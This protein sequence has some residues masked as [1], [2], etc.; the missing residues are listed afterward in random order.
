MNKILVALVFFLIGL[1]AGLVAGY[2]FGS[3]RVTSSEVKQ[4]AHEAGAS[5]ENGASDVATTA[6]QVVDS[7]MIVTLGEQNKSGEVGVATL[8]DQDGQT[9]VVITMASAPNA[10]VSASQPAHIHLGACPSPGAVK[11]PLTNVVNGNSETMVPV[12]IAQLKGM[13]PLAINVHK[14]VAEISKYVACGD[15]K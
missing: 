10:S 8:T 13:L 9:K 2:A 5:L 6:K 15:L 3:G 7:T 12:T 14:S 11:Y 1:L 4:Q